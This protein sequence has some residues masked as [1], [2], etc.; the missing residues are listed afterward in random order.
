MNR[1]T[2]GSLYLVD[3]SHMHVI[4]KLQLNANIYRGEGFQ[5]VIL[6]RHKRN[7]I[8]DVYLREIQENMCDFESQP[9]DEKRNY[10]GK[11]VSHDKNLLCKRQRHG[12]RI[13]G[14]QPIENR[15]P[16]NF[17]NELQLC[18]SE[19][20]ID[21]FN[22]AHRSININAS[23]S[24]LQGISSTLQSN[25]GNPC[26]ND[27]MHPSALTQDQRAHKDSLYNCN[28]S[29]QTFHQR[30]NLTQHQLIHTEEKIFNCDVCHKVF[31][32]H[33][34]L[35]IHQTIH[36]AEKSYKYN[37]CGKTLNC[38]LHLTGHQITHTKENLYKCDICEKVFTQSSYLTVHQRIHTG[39][40]P[41]KCNEC[42]KVFSQNS[43]LAKHRRIHTGE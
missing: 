7:K 6:G 1:I 29:G 21:E 8:E 22:D 28:Q 40:K 33:S 11:H 42:G 2:Y 25:L 12:R 15:L 10:K 35:A 3:I 30:L 26:V 23:F 43:Y 36:T 38:G 17:G 39:E 27:F 20:K 5:T 9:R 18:K 41:Y 13:A 37:E 24:L 16:L 32:Q 14:I 4:K 34:D 19:Q 31:S